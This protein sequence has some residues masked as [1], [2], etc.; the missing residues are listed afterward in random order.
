MGFLTTS[1]NKGI[2]KSFNVVLAGGK[3]VVVDTNKFYERLTNYINEKGIEP[4]S[5][6]QNELEHLL[7]S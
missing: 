2:K 1:A 4:G 5:I 6:S 7:L 3:K